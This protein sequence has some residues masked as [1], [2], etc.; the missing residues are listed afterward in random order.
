MIRNYLKALMLVSWLGLPALFGAALGALD[1][2]GQAVPSEAPDSVTRIGILSHRPL[3]EAFDY[4]QPLQSALEDALPGRRFELLLSDFSRPDA[5]VEAGAVELVLTNPNH[6][7]QLRARQPGMRALATTI[8]DVQGQL[9]PLFGGVIVVRADRSDLAELADLDGVRI[10]AVDP[11]SLG[12]Y[13]AQLFE[14]QQQ[15][16]PLPDLSRVRFTD[17]PHDQVVD[18][19]LNAEVDAGF[20]RTGILEDMAAAGTI[21]LSEIRILNAQDIPGF[22]LALSTRLRVALAC[23][24][25]SPW[26]IAR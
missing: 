18:A 8:E 14:L 23:A 11:Q 21:D 2:A 10:G 26:T 19:V 7:I 24:L 13:R 1:T 5:L 16:L 20:V 9:L 6:F 15:G 12:G 3:D 25:R 4:W 22:P 17:M